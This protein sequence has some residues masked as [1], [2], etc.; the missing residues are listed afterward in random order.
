MSI[1]NINANATARVMKR[2]REED[3][4]VEGSKRSRGLEEPVIRFDRD[5]STQQQKGANGH[6]YKTKS[7]ARWLLD[8]EA[9][10]YGARVWDDV[11]N[12]TWKISFPV[13]DGELWFRV[14]VPYGPL[15]ALEKE[16]SLCAV[17]QLLLY[18]KG[19]FELHEANAEKD[20][21][22]TVEAHWDGV[23][24]QRRRDGGKWMLR[25]EGDVSGVDLLRYLND[26]SFHGEGPFAPRE[27]EE[28]TVVIYSDSE[29]DET[30]EEPEAAEEAK[31]A[32]APK[33]EEPKETAVVDLT[34]EDD[35]ASKETK[36]KPESYTGE[37]G[38]YVELVD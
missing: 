25:Y 32:T 7:S 14:G 13:G 15:L 27:C 5:E 1:E 28:E 37:D 19:C 2:G 3:S 22:V 8:R 35:P 6:E 24:V 38:V 31:A 20:L 9:D 21:S 26:K 30:E 10:V 16:L 36:P 29:D 11:V 12:G 33:T 4:Q 17:Q 18:A 34:G 23:A